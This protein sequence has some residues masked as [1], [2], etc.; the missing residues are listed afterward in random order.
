MKKKER[1]EE[2]E[3]ERER[4]REKKREREEIWDHIAAALVL[5]DGA[6]VKHGAAAEAKSRRKRTASV[7]AAV[8]R[9][10][11][12]SQKNFEEREKKNWQSE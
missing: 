12:F 9:R 8:A 10:R 6:S 3:R 7:R 4:E 1:E 11:V 5:D 2:R